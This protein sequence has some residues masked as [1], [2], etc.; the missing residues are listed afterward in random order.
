MGLIDQLRG[1]TRDAVMKALG[2]Q[3]A[4]IELG[5]IQILTTGLSTAISTDS[6]NPTVIPIASTVHGNGFFSDPNDHLKYNEPTCSSPTAESTGFIQ[7]GNSSGQ[8]RELNFSL[9]IS[10]DDGVTWTPQEPFVGV[11][12]ALVGARDGFQSISMN[13]KRELDAF[14]DGTL[15][16]W[17]CYADSAG[18]YLK[19][20]D[21]AFASK[22]WM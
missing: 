17:S 18:V 9:D 5:F 2:I 14:P 13:F 7:F 16:R 6:V 12:P 19:T 21:I 8:A 15:V 1:V 20:V 11:V 4:F 10:I 3:G 22:A